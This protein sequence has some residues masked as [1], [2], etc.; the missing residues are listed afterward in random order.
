MSRGFFARP[1]VDVARDLLGTLLHRD[2]SDGATVGRIVEVE[3][4][5][6]PTDRASHA[7]AGLTR[8]TTPMFGEVGHAYVYL[9]YGM[10]NCLNVV[11]YDSSLAPAG[12]VLLR[13]LE[14][15]AGSVLMGA[16]RG[17]DGE[18]DSRLCSGPARLCQAMAVDRS[19][20]AHD[21]TA[22]HGLS[23]TAGEAIPDSQVATGPRIGVD[24]AGKWAEKPW[25]FWIVGHPSLSRR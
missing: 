18:P 24:Y 3:A 1:T 12:A 7:R 5:D 11:A 23:L 21:L 20:N 13:A 16:R 2:S 14:P 25:R 19:L 6:G 22:G 15:V 9:I 4:Y 10:H 17:R 8:R